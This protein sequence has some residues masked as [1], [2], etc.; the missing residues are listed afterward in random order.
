LQSPSAHGKAVSAPPQQPASTMFCSGSERKMPWTG[1]MSTEEVLNATEKYD[2]F[3]NRCWYAVAGNILAKGMDGFWE[4]NW[5]DGL[6]REGKCVFTNQTVTRVNGKED[7]SPVWLGHV[8]DGVLSYTMRAKLCGMTLPMSEVTY[9]WLSFPKNDSYTEFWCVA[10][11]APM[12][13]PIVM[14]FCLDP[15]VKSEKVDAFIE[16]LKTKHGVAFTDKFNRVAY[17]ADFTPGSMG[18]FAFNKKGGKPT[19]DHA[20]NAY[21]TQVLATPY[22]PPQK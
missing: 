12:I 7:V 15:H 5:W 8:V 2:K 6:A 4:I 19:I 21:A 11:M 13:G 16:T 14:V 1:A 20:K 3:M 9:E 17:P 10:A 22:P 18:E